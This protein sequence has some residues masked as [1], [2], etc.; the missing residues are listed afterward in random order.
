MSSTLSL[1]ITEK[2]KVVGTCLGTPKH[3]HNLTTTQQDG[4][5]ALQSPHKVPITMFSLCVAKIPCE[6]GSK[7]TKSMKCHQISHF[8]LTKAKHQYSFLCKTG[9]CEQYRFQ[10]IFFLAISEKCKLYVFLGSS[11]S[12]FYNKNPSSNI[13]LDFRDSGATFSSTQESLLQ[14]ILIALALFIWLCLF[15]LCILLL[16][17]L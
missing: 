2:R 11:S 12:M 9:N 16:R 17:G 8:L 3:P 4:S 5:K 6:I 15:S 10:P 1:L 14:G 7:N 13:T